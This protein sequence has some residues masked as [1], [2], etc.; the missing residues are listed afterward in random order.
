M[1]LKVNIQRRIGQT[2]FNNK[3]KGTPDEINIRFVTEYFDR[4]EKPIILIINSSFK[5]A[6]VPEK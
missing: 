6:I 3:N 1:D 4:I 2:I 5:K